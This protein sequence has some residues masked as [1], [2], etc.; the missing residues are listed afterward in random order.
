MRLQLGASPVRL[1]VVIGG[2]TLTTMQGR[3]GAQASPDADSFK[4]ASP[5]ATAAASAHA[6][7]LSEHLATEY[8]QYADTDHVFVETPS[9]RGTVYDPTAGWSVGGQYLVD[10]VSAASVDIVSTASRRW[11]EVRQEGSLEASY[12]PK[13]FGVQAN[14]TLSDEPDYVSWS[15]G[16]AITQDIMSDS[17]TWLLG[18][19]RG[20]D[21]AGRTG[22]SFSV[23]SR[24]VDRNAFKAALTLVLGPTTVASL[25]G[26]LILENGDQSK[27]YRYIPLF[28]AGTNVPRGAPIAFV[29][30]L[31]ASARPL[32]QLPLSRQRYGLT[33]RVA[34]RYHLATLRLDERLYADSWAM[35]ATTTDARYLF[36]LSRRV[37]LG[38]HA[39][40]HAQSSVD[41]WRRAYLFGPGFDY[42]ALRTGDRE[43]GPLVNLTGGW[44]LRTGLGADANPT[45]W[46]LGFDLN[47]T[48]TQYLDD[49]YLTRRVSVLGVVT[50]ETDL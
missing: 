30:N 14:G 49:L 24:A 7:S 27:P 3:A 29:N 16:G 47:I 9:I 35:K 11:Q 45:S 44:T 18:Y 2:L 21:V 1:G 17:V 34:H 42:P 31:R 39:R 20:H 48:S 15:G 10:V 32:E 33:M 50:L 22:T 36:D 43:L 41:F 5:P 38:P 13:A 4:T 25:L 8:G 46:V 23:F 26:D 40:L 6:S 19:A 28:A 12:K 37:E